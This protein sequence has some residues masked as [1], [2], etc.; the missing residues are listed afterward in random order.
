MH[1][2]LYH[3]F[4]AL[5]TIDTFYAQNFIQLT[6]IGF[7]VL[8]LFLWAIQ[9]RHRE[10]L[11]K[12]AVSW[13]VKL[14]TLQ[15]AALAFT[16]ISYVINYLKANPTLYRGMF[17]SGLILNDK[18]VQNAWTHIFMICFILGFG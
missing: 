3:T 7:M 17:L 8:I 2:T 11:A 4:F 18:P 12:S 5:L 14:Y 1:L 10:G 6:V 9:S 15:L 16:Q 13:S